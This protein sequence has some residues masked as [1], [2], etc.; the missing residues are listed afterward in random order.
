MFKQELRLKYKDKRKSITPNALQ[1]ISE[2]I[3]EL[4]FKN[5]N[6]ENKLLSLFLP[7]ENEKEINTYLILE[8]ANTLDAKIAIPKSNFENNELKHILFEEKTELVLNKYGIPEPCKGK[9]VAA[10]KIDYVIVP[11]LAIDKSGNRVGYGKGFYDR[12]LKK[13]N[14]HCKFIGI[15]HFEEFEQIDDVQPTD[16]KLN[17]LITP[18]SFHWFER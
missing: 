4:F 11:L 12:F 1:T 14:N 10:D 5:I 13:C 6:V 16:I 9:V 8:K 7:I 3:A 17:A 15:T 2:S 18:N